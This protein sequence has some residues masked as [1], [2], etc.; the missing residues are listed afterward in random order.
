MSHKITAGLI[1]I[2]LLVISLVFFVFKTPQSV[3]LTEVDERYETTTNETTKSHE[4]VTQTESDTTLSRKISPKKMAAYQNFSSQSLIQGRTIW[5]GTCENCHGYG[6]AGA[7]IP[8]Q[9]SDWKERIEKERATLYDHAIN[10]FFGPDD[11]MMPERGG[12]PELTDDEVKAAVDYMVALAT[13]Y[14]EKQ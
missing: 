13:Y 5:L 11:T 12:N 7:P 1:V 3:S 6:T 2:L 10:G 9:P 8:M 4:Q 14:I